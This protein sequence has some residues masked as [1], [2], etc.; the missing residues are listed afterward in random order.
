MIFFPSKSLSDFLLC[1]HES[2]TSHH[3]EF[4]LVGFSADPQWQLIL[5]GIFLTICLITLLGNMTLLVLI[6][7]HSRLHTPMYFFIGNLSFLDFW[8]TSVYAPKLLA[9]CVSE[10]KRIPLAGCEAPVF[11]S[12]VV[13]YTESYLVAATAVDCYMAICSFV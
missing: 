7:V 8:Y 5:F 3:A 4:I 2:G 9:S 12:C 10:D 13:T 6:C 11:S 1:D